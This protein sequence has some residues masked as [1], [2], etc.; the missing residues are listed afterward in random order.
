MIRCS[1]PTKEMMTIQEE[2]ERASR[3]K[4][5]K[6]KVGCF[7]VA[8]CAQWKK[9]INSATWERAS[10]ICKNSMKRCIFCITITLSPRS[11]LMAKQERETFTYRLENMHFCC[12][13]SLLANINWN[14]FLFVISIFFWEECVMF[15]MLEHVLHVCMSKR[16][17]CLPSDTDSIDRSVSL[18]ERT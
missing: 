13:V 17:L 15:S 5:V 2:G 1:I 9:K 4:K 3:R 12:C 7:Y 14:S 18:C 16:E 8:D 11:Q 10:I 6:I